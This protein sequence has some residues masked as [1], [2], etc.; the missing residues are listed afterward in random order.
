VDNGRRERFEHLV[1]EHFDAVLGFALARVEP[2]AARDAVAETFLAAWKSLDVLPA[3]PR[4][5]LLAV[6]RRRVADH[7]RAV[8]LRETLVGSLSVRPAVMTPDPADDVVERDRIRAAFATLSPTD[9]EVLRLLA[10]DGLTRGEAA[11]VLGFGP[12]VFAVR[13]H[14]A[15]RRLRH[16]LDGPDAE[17]GHG[18]HPSS[19]Q[20][21]SYESERPS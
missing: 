8:G 20:A 9:Q 7:Y 19:V 13:L 5:W 12:A 3:E 17:A 16:A 1:A 10:W 18:G 15:R 6:A 2:E 21:I 14:R 4:G 11:Q